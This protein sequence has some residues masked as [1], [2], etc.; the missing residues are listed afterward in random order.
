MDSQKQ[1]KS[2]RCPSQRS[3]GKY[4]LCGHLL[5]A[6]E[7]DNIILYCSECKIFYK[8]TIY[9]DGFVEMAPLPK[10]QRINFVNTLRMI[11]D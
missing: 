9:E 10:N 3:H 11:V 7:G 4:D 2:L 5:G 8:L 1:V 6:I